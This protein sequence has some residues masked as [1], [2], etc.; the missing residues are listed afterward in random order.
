MKS[1]DSQKTVETQL[2]RNLEA[3]LRF[4][5][6]RVDDPDLAADVLQESLLKATRAADSLEDQE[7][8]LPWFYMILRNTISDLYRKQDAERRRLLRLEGGPDLQ[9]DEE[10]EKVLC[11]C[12]HSLI[13]TLKTE[14]ADLISELDL[15]GASPKEVAKRLG[16][17][18]N[19]LKVR[20]HRARNQL[21]KRLEDTCKICTKHG[22]LDCTCA[23]RSSGGSETTSL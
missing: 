5:Q 1:A 16:L 9:M 19:N 2:L 11:E 17:T 12:I 6:K 23:D 3:L 8:V 22:C 14:Y 7:K 15:G 18:I 4:V 10:E 13:P 20:R 21:R